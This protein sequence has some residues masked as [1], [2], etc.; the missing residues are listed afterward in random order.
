MGT[1]LSERIGGWKSKNKATDRGLISNHLNLPFRTVGH[2]WATFTLEFRE[3]YE[4][5]RKDIHLWTPQGPAQFHFF[6]LL[7][8]CT[9][10]QNS[11]VKCTKVKVKAA[12]SCLTLVIP[13]TLALQ[14]PFSMA[15]SRQEYWSGEPFHSPVALLNLGIEPRSSALQA[16]S[17]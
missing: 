2:D 1:R 15:F 8:L 5:H 16:E 14:A 11:V 17:L 9:M 4:G 13:W 12:Q 7:N 3:S 10:N 6:W